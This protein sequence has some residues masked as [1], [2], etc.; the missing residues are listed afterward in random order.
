[1]HEKSQIHPKTLERY[2]AGLRKIASNIHRLDDSSKRA[3]SRAQ[4]DNVKLATLTA[5]RI[6]EW[7]TRFIRRG[8][9][10]PLAEKSAKVSSNSFIG[11]AR[12]LFSANVIA[13]VKDIVE[14]PSPASFADVKVE[15]SR[16]TRYRSTFDTATLLESAWTELATEKPEQFKIFLLGAMAGLRRNEIDKLP[17]TAFRWDKGLIRIE[18]TEFFRPK[19]HESAGDV[20]VDS[21]VLEIFCGYFTQAKSEFVLDSG[22][23]P[24]LNAPFERCR[25]GREFAELIAWPFARRAS[26]RERRF[27]R[28][29]KSSAARSARVTVFSLQA[30][31]CVMRISR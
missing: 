28:C 23:E 25:C 9:T 1:M 22:N 29:A 5:E 16:A 11:C 27:M 14:I 4:V 21:K 2:S 13:R 12:S 10:T 26:F 3:D 8:S 20:V 30:R 19:S 6:E 15:R 18:A 24:D 17:W 31:C 7:R